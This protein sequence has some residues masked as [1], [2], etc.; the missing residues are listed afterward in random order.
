MRF[1]I[2][3]LVAGLASIFLYPYAKAGGSWL[4]KKFQDLNKKLND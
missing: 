2:L 3:S 4:Y 1:I